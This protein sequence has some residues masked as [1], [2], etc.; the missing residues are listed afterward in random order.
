MDNEGLRIAYELGSRAIT[1][2]ASVL[3]GL[4]SRA[5]TVFAAAA[6]VTSFFGGQA[7]TARAHALHGG[8]TAAA[9]ALFVCCA[10]LT[11]AVMWP[12]DFAFSLSAGELIGILDARPGNTPSSDEVYREIALRLDENYDVNA[13]TIQRLFWCFRVA[14]LVLVVEVGAW[15]VVIWRT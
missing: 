6:V 12:F 10:L 14:I 11:L 15:I 1:D 5:G 2:Q 4:R 13:A 8:F 3:D 9:F 7:L